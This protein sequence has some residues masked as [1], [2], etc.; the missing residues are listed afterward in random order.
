VFDAHGGVEWFGNYHPDHGRARFWYARATRLIGGIHFQSDRGTRALCRRA[1]T[2]VSVLGR[3]DKQF[4]TTPIEIVGSEVL[5]SAL[6]PADVTGD[7]IPWRQ[8]FRSTISSVSGD[9]ISGPSL[10][11][12]VSRRRHPDGKFGAARS[13]PP[14][15]QGAFGETSRSV[16]VQGSSALPGTKC[17]RRPLSDPHLLLG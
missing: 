3:T 14:V 17:L 11:L 10:F 6:L 16:M 8:R 13:N 9:G 15:P 2:S 7:S 5:G 12:S 1:S 4:G